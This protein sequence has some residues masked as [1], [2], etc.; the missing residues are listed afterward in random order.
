MMFYKETNFKDTEIGKIPE[1]WKVVKISSLFDMYKGTT[2]STKIKEYWNGEIPFVT[3]TDI[4]KIANQN[5]IYL[6]STEKYITKK[7]LESK[8][9]KLIPENSLLFTSRATIGYVAIN[10]IKVAINQGVIALVPRG[11][12][13][14]AFF[15][16]L[17]QQMKD[18][19]K[20]LAGG[21]TYKEISMSTLGDV[22]IPLPPLPEQKIIAEILSTI[23]K[24]I[25]KNSEIIV[26]TERLKKGLMQALLTGRVRV[27]VKSGKISFYKETNFKNTEIGR[28]PEDWKV[29]RLKDVAEIRKNKVRVSKGLREVAFIPMELIPNSEIFVKYEIRNINSISSATYCEANDLLLAKITPSFENGKQGIVPK[30]V[31]NGFA[32]ATTEVY[33]IVCKKID[34]LFLFYILK[35]KRFRKILEFSMRGTTGRKRV[36][37][38]A[39]ENLRIPLPP[40]SEQQIIGEILSTLDRKLELERM[41]KERL[42]RIKR[43]LMGVLLTGKVRVKVVGVGGGS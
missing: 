4:T 21:S 17:F 37:K 29:V 8:G 12:I 36:P 13:E 3:P 33:P 11:D 1:D 25:E 34:N 32:F 23:D 20:K 28:I 16:Y 43:G 7:G 30:K 10:K 24:A 14:I 26:K 27:K 6:E 9:L 41:K 40:L 42:E 39:L 35:L 22:K 15:Y 31:P 18:V 19:F 38:E 2:P 5:K